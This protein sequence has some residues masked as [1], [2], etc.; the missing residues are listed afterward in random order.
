ML[1]LG[2]LVINM[3]TPFSDF[4]CSLSLGMLL[5]TTHTT[6]TLGIT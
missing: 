4:S 1:E 6:P 2:L 5:V 3:A